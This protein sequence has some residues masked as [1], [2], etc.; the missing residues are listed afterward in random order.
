MSYFTH[1]VR[2][3]IAWQG[4]ARMGWFNF[5]SDL[6]YIIPA[7]AMVPG[8]CTVTA[9]AQGQW[10]IYINH[11][12]LEA[13]RLNTASQETTSSLEYFDCNRAHFKSLFGSFFPDE[14]TQALS[15]VEPVAKVSSNPSCIY[16]LFLFIL[17][18]Y[19]MY[20]FGI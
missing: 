5:S 1:Q 17:L 16:F 10:D 15:A 4:L 11:W 8:T 18:L 3:F 19:F 13:A 2:W 9:T 20:S 6:G 7:N 12:A 14:T